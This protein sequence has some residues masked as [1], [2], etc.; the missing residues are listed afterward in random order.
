MTNHDAVRSE[1]APVYRPAL[2]PGSNNDDAIIE[3]A[4]CIMR[5]RVSRGKAITS[6]KMAAEYFILRA[7]SLDVEE[8]GVLFLDGQHRVI[9]FQ[10]LFSGTV[11]GCSVYPREIVKAVLDCGAVAVMLTHNHP[12]GMPEPSAPDRNITKL[13]AD[14]LNTIDVRVLDHIVTGG[15][16][17]VSFA[18]RNEI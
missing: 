5:E 6:P 8:F 18:E 4:L 3:Q 10:V 13:I 14:A 12:S 11:N 17:Y 1:S 9:R 7:H 15:G 2:H 16:D